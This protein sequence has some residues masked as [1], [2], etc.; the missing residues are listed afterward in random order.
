MSGRINTG[1]DRTVREETAILRRLGWRYEGVD[2]AGHHRFSHPQYGEIPMAMTPRNPKRFR[3]SH[4]SRVAGLMGLSLWQFEQ[5]IAGQAP[6][7]RPRSKRRRQPRSRRPVSLLIA[8][9]ER[10]VPVS[11][12][13]TED[14]CGCG[15]KWLSDL[16]PA[17][18]LCPA[19]DRLVA[20][21]EGAS[22]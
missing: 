1:P 14:L 9:Q 18:R 4:R 10:H 15:R 22:Q 6:S 3:I 13:A 20:L 7:K 21:P 17:G 5:V 16:S 2:N 12:D 11:V 8:A 19:C